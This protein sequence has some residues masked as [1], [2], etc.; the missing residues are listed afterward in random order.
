MPEP[1]SFTRRFHQ[2]ALDKVIFQHVVEAWNAGNPL[3]SRPQ[4]ADRYLPAKIART[5]DFKRRDIEAAMLIWMDNDHLVLD[6][7]NTRSPRGLRVEKY[8]LGWDQ[9]ENGGAEVGS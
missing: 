1:D 4:A 3:S 5:T 9:P 6:R 2:R 7:K 8:P